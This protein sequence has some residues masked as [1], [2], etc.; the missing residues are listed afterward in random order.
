MAI[1]RDEKFKLQNH[2]EVLIRSYVLGDQEAIQQ[3]AKK[4]ATETTHTLKYEA[5]PDL[6]NDQLKYHCMVF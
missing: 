3:L 1:L 4:V 6:T 5:T 2:Q